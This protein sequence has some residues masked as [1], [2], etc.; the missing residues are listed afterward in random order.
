MCRTL[1][2]HLD[3][4]ILTREQEL[5]AMAALP[6]SFTVWTFGFFCNSIL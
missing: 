2:K 3:Q 6:I 5:P 4:F 1:G